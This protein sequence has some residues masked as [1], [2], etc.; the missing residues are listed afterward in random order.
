MG[1]NE[2]KVPQVTVKRLS[3]YLRALERFQERGYETNVVILKEPVG[4][5]VYEYWNAEDLREAYRYHR[6]K[7]IREIIDERGRCDQEVK[8]G[9]LRI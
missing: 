7:F 2:K 1:D 9:Q 5:E 8:E 3:R 4:D 6:G